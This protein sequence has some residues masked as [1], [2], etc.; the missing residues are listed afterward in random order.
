MAVDHEPRRDSLSGYLTTGHE[1]NGITELNTPVP[2]SWK[3]RLET[4][5]S[6]RAISVADLV[7]LYLRDALYGERSK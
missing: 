6:E 7:R 1:W 3:R 4:I 5:A 2:R